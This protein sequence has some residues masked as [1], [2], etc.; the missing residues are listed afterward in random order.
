MPLEGDYNEAIGEA[1][2]ARRPLVQQLLNE[3]D[4]DEAA[5]LA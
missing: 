5:T 3:V 4:G 2:A 1:Y